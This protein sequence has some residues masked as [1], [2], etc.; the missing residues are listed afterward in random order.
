M[1]A[2]GGDGRALA[3]DRVHALAGR[4]ARHRP[5]PI[6]TP[7]GAGPWPSS[8]RSGPRSGTSSTC[9]PTA[10]TTPSSAPARCPA[11]SGSPAPASTTPSTS[12]AIATTARSPSCT[13]PSCAS[14]TSSP[15]ASCG[16]GSPRSPPACAPTG[17]AGRPGRRLPAQHPGGDRR[18]P[19]HRLPRARSGPHARRT[20]APASVVDRF[21]QIEPKVLFCVDGYRYGGRDFDRRDVVASL[22]EQMPTLERTV[23][24]PYLDPAP[25]LGPLRGAVTWDELASRG[26]GAELTFERVP[27]DRR[28][29]GSSTRPGR[30]AC[31]RRSSRARAAS[32][33][34]T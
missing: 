7:S 11:P 8:R 10:A 9:R 26:E 31:R 24:L 28:R 30:P 21:A 22:Q 32:S 17:S 16:R 29:S 34:S 25:D 4:R 3:D 18:L 27:F 19:R 13:R 12:S 1:A 23:V 5:P 20:S 2:L 6:T 14:S 33:S 15:G